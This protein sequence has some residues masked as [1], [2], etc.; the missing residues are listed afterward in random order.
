MTI[1]DIKIDTALNQLVADLQTA[2]DYIATHGLTKNMFGC[3]GRGAC[4]VGAL[5]WAIG[6]RE[7]QLE[8]PNP[9]L[10][11]AVY[12][13]AV[14]LGQP[15]SVSSWAAR[16]ALYEF[17]DHPESEQADIIGLFDTTIQRLAA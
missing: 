3:F 7:W 6:L 11:S 15:A 4:T 13:L 9:R 5:L 14:T 1:T 2:R 12:A 8:S 17:N 16:V 10:R